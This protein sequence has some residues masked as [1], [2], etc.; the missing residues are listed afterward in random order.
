VSPLFQRDSVRAKA[1]P[2]MKIV[3]KVTIILALIIPACAMG[4]SDRGFTILRY[5]SQDVDSVA[6]RRMLDRFEWISRVQQ[7]QG[8]DAPVTSRDDLIECF[9]EQISSRFA[10][11]FAF[12]NGRPVPM[13]DVFY[14][15]ALEVFGG[16]DVYV[17]S[18][19]AMNDSNP[20]S[21][22]HGVY[23]KFDE[24][25]SPPQTFAPANY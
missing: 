25:C 11:D 13:D 6:N 9:L 7:R 12:A 20:F 21:Y 2:A 14:I 1:K 19:S 3:L 23:Y 4:P 18:Y 17:E 8:Q 22:S 24:A 15:I 5:P 10:D 16:F